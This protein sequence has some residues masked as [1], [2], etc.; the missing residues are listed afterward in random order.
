M[1]LLHFLDPDRNWRS[2]DKVEHAAFGFGICLMATGFM[3]GLAAFGFTLLVAAVYEA[4]QTDTAHSV[5]KLGQ[6]GFG[7]SLLDQAF[8]TAGALL[9]LALR[10][11]L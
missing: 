9:W 2:L 10:A 11:A 1:N 3:S 7:F 6:V 5:G 8:S 4:G